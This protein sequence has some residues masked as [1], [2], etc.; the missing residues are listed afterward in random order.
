MVLESRLA[1][2]QWGGIVLYSMPY[3][4][5]GLS[6]PKSARQGLVV[7][8]WRALGEGARRGCSCAYR[9]ELH[10]IT[11]SMSE[12]RKAYEAYSD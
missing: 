7:A 11:R 4:T 9:T 12:V 10:T 5:A 1:G 3:P 8:F 6:L 2:R